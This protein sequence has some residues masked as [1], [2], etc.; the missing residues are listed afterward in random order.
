MY[1]LR[2][3]GWVEEFFFALKRVRLS[4]LDTVFLKVKEFH[5]S[6]AISEHTINKISI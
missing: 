4:R 5:T 3:K 1:F 2:F 6:K